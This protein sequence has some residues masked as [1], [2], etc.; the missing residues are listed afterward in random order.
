MQ[1]MIKNMLLLVVLSIALNGIVFSA[2][3]QESE[4]A[5]NAARVPTLKLNNGTEIPQLGIGTFMLGDNNGEAYQA[6]LTAL[7]LGYRHIDT[8][9]AYQNENSV[10]RAI[11]DSGVSR[12]DIWVT[13]KLWPGDYNDEKAVD[14]M[15]ERLGLEYIDLVYLHQPMGDYMSGWN[16]LVK[17]QKDGKVRALGIS[18]FDRAEDLFDEFM[19]QAKVKPQMLQME[20]HPYAQRV[21]WQKKLKEHNIQQ[22]NWYP[23]GGRASAGALLKDETI[24]KIAKAKGKSPAQII[25]RWH[26]QEGFCVIP[27]ASNPDYLKEDIEIFDFSLSNEEMEAIRGMNGERLFFT[28]PMRNRR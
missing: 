11:K 23:L 21:E 12:E 2:D 22:E 20:C 25:L 13:S 26:I 1:S 5:K 28:T 19:K 6:V 10:G 24:N 9:H 15:L 8:A 14:K 7:K 16:N 27:G 4:G 17:A 3:D 18:N